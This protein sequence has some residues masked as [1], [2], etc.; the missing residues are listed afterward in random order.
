MSTKNK[1]IARNAPARPHRSSKLDDVR[2]YFKKW[3][4]KSNTLD[5]DVEEDFMKAVQIAMAR[6][7]QQQ[8]DMTQIGGQDI[9]KDI[10]SK[11]AGLGPWAAFIAGLAI[12]DDLVR[13]SGEM[14]PSQQKEWDRTIRRQMRR[15]SF[16]DKD[17]LR[18]LKTFMKDSNDT[19]VRRTPV[20]NGV[21][22]EKKLSIPPFQGAQWDPS[23]HRWVK[24][25]EIGNSVINRG[26][27][28]RV[29]GTGAGVHSR[30]VG[31]HGKG[32]LRATRRPIQQRKKQ[33]PAKRVKH[34]PA[35]TKFLAA[36]KK[37]KK[38]QSK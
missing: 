36:T 15:K 18:K 17:L 12:S 30:S 7:S 4:K 21:K 1:G 8:K 11:S 25:G 24:Q 31:G 26:G 37:K 20:R 33:S 2:L 9:F 5:I 3:K 22:L 16:D 10:L 6:K 27:K 14:T 23:I 35:V 13:A 29:R 32:G 19:Y 38:K 34:S 28:K